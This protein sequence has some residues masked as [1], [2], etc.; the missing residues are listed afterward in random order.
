MEG[1]VYLDNMGRVKK[2]LR[3]APEAREKARKYLSE[4]FGFDFD[5]FSLDLSGFGMW[6]QFFGIHL[7]NAVVEVICNLFGLERF[8][9][10]YL[11]DGFSTRNP[12]KMSLVKMKVLFPGKNGFQ[13]GTYRLAEDYVE[14]QVIEDMEVYGGFDRS[15]LFHRKTMEKM[16]YTAKSKDISHLLLE[17]TKY[18][19]SNMGKDEAV[20]VFSNVF[21]IEK[22]GKHRIRRRYSFSRKADAYIS[23]SGAKTIQFQEMIDLA[24]KDL[25]LPSS[26]TYYSEFF[27]FIPGILEESFIQIEA[28]FETAE[29]EILKPALKGFWKVKEVTGCFPALIPIIDLNLDDS[30][31]FTRN[32][33]C[34]CLCRTVEEMIETVSWLND[35]TIS[36][37]DLSREVGKKLIYGF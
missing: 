9:I 6:R 7:E 22:T 5:D 29:P 26:E 30:L 28:E 3:R 18:G 14:N 2:R 13:I 4:K 19:L 10:T 25:V 11:L 17:F 33:G 12:F 35:R 36:F 21:V 20:N 16:G 27:F 8:D 1:F 32:P 34:V 15:Y 23:K 37:T 31:K 24:E